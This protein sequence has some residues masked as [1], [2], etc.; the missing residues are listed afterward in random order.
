MG[1]PVVR[2]PPNPRF[3][4]TA[5][6]AVRAVKRYDVGRRK[7]R[8]KKFTKLLAGFLAITLTG[9]TI[10]AL[11]NNPDQPVVRASGLMIT[12]DPNMQVSWDFAYQ[13]C[14]KLKLAGHDDWRLPIIKEMEAISEANRSRCAPSGIK[15]PLVTF[16]CL[17]YWAADNNGPTALSYGF[18][19]EDV[20]S[21][22]KGYM[23]LVICVR[24]E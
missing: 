24:T 18:D 22:G 20:T 2:E 13:F 15:Y 3:H 7:L 9:C 21:Q 11:A 12:G 23:N 19:D 1:V 14:S 17:E 6:F 16:G 10:G 8:E 5:G 4:R